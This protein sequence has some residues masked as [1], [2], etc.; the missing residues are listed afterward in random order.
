MFI[1][2]RKVSCCSSSWRSC[3]HLGLFPVRTTWKVVSDLLMER[4]KRT[5]HVK[6]NSLY[7]FFA[8]ANSEKRSSPASGRLDTTVIG[9]IKGRGTKGTEE[10]G[11]PAETCSWHWVGSLLQDHWRNCSERESSSWTKCCSRL[12]TY[13]LI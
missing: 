1:V 5:I 12:H 8:Q 10:R 3:K 13:A 11:R 6:S 7:F 9:C 2:S 4:I